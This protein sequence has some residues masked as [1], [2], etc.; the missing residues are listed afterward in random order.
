MEVVPF[1]NS[2]TPGPKT[3]DFDINQI[4]VTP[5]R[6]KAVD[7]SDSYY[8]VEPGGRRD[9]GHADRRG[10]DARG[11]Q[12]VQARR[13]ARD[14]ELRVHPGHD[15]ADEAAVG[16]HLE[17][18]RVQALKN[19]QIDGLVVDLPTAFYIT[20]GR[21]RTAKSSASSRR[22]PGGEHFGMVF[23]KGNAL[24]ACVNKALVGAQADG[25]LKQLQQQW[26][27]KATGAPVLK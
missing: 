25:T 27:A 21:C 26:L 15:Q 8:D 14:D 7:F 3:F 11:A 22:R 17:R 4:S 19:K 18:R 24:V 13:P 6:A 2:F 10:Q 5:E 20:A 23:A 12:A 9:Q 1:N 16:L